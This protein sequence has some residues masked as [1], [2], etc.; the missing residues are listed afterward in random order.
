MAA[1]VGIPLPL[2][3][4]LVFTDSCTYLTE[5]KV[6]LRLVV[7]CQSV[8]LGAKPFETHKESFFNIENVI[9]RGCKWNEAISNRKCNNLSVSNRNCN[10]L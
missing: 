10:Y 7:Y 1:T 3:S 4:V 9:I 2:G 5:V 8:C 6:T